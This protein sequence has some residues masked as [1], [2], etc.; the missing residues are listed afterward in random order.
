MNTKVNIKM[1]WMLLAC[2]P[3]LGLVVGCGGSSPAAVTL[4]QDAFAQVEGLGDVAGDE[5][6]FNEAFVAGAAPEN[7][8]DYAVRGY[9][10]VGEPEVTGE[11]ATLTVKIFGGVHATG[12]SDRGSAGSETAE[13]EQTWTLQRSGEEWKIKDAPLG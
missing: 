7:R 10:V 3:V 8:K 6:L 9:Q 11:S 5:T 13:V 12:G 4:K 2:L 1:K